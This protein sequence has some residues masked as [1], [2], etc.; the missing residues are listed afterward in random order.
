MKTQSLSL[1]RAPKLLE[2]LS[3]EAAK[4]IEDITIDSKGRAIPKLYGKLQAN[5]ELRAM[6]NISAEQ[7]APDV[8]QL[9]NEELV[10]QFA[11]QAKELGVEIDLS[12]KAISNRQYCLAGKSEIVAPEGWQ[13]WAL[14]DTVAASSFLRFAAI[15]SL[16]R[17]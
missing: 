16:E 12:A 14:I 3:P 8:T 15:Q 10:A 11:Q 17:I 2:D 1:K 4:L 5:K 7:S 6:L 13:F 9:S